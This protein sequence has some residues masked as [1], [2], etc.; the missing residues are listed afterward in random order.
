MRCGWWPLRYPSYSSTRSTTNYKPGVRAC[1]TTSTLPTMSSLAETSWLTTFAVNSNWL[2]SQPS[3][4]SRWWVQPGQRWRLTPATTRRGASSCHGAPIQLFPSLSLKVSCVVSS[5][6]RSFAIPERLP[7]ICAM[8]LSEF[9]IRLGF[10]LRLRM[11]ICVRWRS[12]LWVTRVD[13][14]AA[15]WMLTDR[16]RRAV[17]GSWSVQRW[18]VTDLNPTTLADG[19]QSGSD[20]ESSRPRE[21]KVVGGGAVYQTQEP[22]GAVGPDV[23]LLALPA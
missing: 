13:I 19:S 4:W 2:G 11:M 6:R 22:I 10:R 5:K 15:R 23:N 21:Q 7:H 12:R 20:V 9:S 14:V 8:R 3:E 16:D 1:L 18:A 17:A